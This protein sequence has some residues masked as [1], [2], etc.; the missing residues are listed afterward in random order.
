VRLARWVVCAI[1]LAIA[2]SGAA[3]TDEENEEPTYGATGVAERPIVAG[4]E[5]DPTASA[6]VIR[7]DARPRTV[8]TLDEALLDAPGARARRTGAFG[9]FTA[10]SLRGAEAEQTTVLLGD[11]PISSPDGSAFD[12]SSVPTWL[13]SRVEVYRGGAPAWLSAGAIGGVLRL[14]P[15][16]EAGQRYEGVLSAGSFDLGQVRAAASVGD[17]R[18]HV[19]TAAGLTTFGGRFPYVDDNHTA[20]VPTDDVVRERVGADFLEGSGMIS[21]RGR[22][23]DVRLESAWLGTGRVGGLAAV[24]SRFADVPQGRRSTTRLLGGVTA[25]LAEDDHYRIALALGVGLERRSVSDPL[26]Q[27]GLLPR[28]TDDLLWRATARLAGTLRALDWLDLTLIGGY[29]HEAIAPWDRRATTQAPASA[30]DGAAV[31]L[32]GRAFGTIDSTRFEIRPSGRVEVLEAH[33]FDLAEGRTGAPTSSTTVVPTGRLG[34]VLEPVRGVAISASGYAAAR[35][36]SLV[37]LFGDRSY[38]VGNATLVPETS[39]GV[40]GGIVL[41]GVEG[42]LRGSLDIRGFGSSVTHLIRY[43]RTTA[44]QSVPENIDSATL[45]GVEASLSASFER[46][47]HLTSAFTWLDARESTRGRVLPL[48]PPIALYT[49]LAAN[50]DSIDIVDRIAGFADVEYVAATYQDPENTT[51]IPGRVRVGLG[52]SITLLE[53]HVSVELVVRDLFDARGVDVLGLPLAG[54]SFVGSL[55]LRE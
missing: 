1:V 28:D 21:M 52:A 39:F 7:L 19:T 35:P 29:T 25:Q 13:L 48:R 34:V 37:E 46:W 45:A 8:E 27:F 41:S 55:T 47:L 5:L 32:E 49:R 22:L 16:D 43:V 42:P 26:A 54:R 9:G 14:V 30:R 50:S 3:Q 12:L 6:T 17:D 38:L 4:S 53:E 31:S 10:L 40:D 18:L 20:F 23:G 33:L 2:S 44:N 24:P 36:P 51:T 15:R 11:V